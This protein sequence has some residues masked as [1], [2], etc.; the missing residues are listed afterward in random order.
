MP[1]GPGERHRHHLHRAED[2]T[3][4]DEGQHQ[5]LE[6]AVADRRAAAAVRGRVDGRLGAALGGEQHHA[7]RQ[8][9]PGQQDAG[10]REGGGGQADR[11]DRA[12]DEAD[13]VHHRLVRVRGVQLGG[14][15]A[16]QMRPAGPDHRAGAG[17]AAHRGRADEQ[18]PGGRAEVGAEQ[19]RGRRR[20]GD[21]GRGQRHPALPVAVHQPGDLRADRGG[22]QRQHRRHRAG[23]PVRAAQLR[24][25]GEDADAGHRDR[26]PGDETGGREGQS[27]GYG[28]DLA[29][30]GQHEGS[31]SSKEHCWQ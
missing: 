2:R 26:Q 5:H 1:A 31:A 3:G 28:E 11:E 12:D 6:P 4:G 23:H 22:R 10:L 18:R 14:V 15:V 27:A 8:E 29:V 20:H 9:D 17:H 25:H 30:A 7:H 24:Q 19:Q 16:V 21:R 13:L